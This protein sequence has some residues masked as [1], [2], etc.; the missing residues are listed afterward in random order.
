MANVNSIV[1]EPREARP[2]DI[3]KTTSPHEKDLAQV[4]AHSKEDD[5]DDSSQFK[6]DGVKQVEAVTQVWDKK[7][8]WTVFGL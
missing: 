2:A 3:E 4:A 7:A 6:Q 5:S 1:G 8:L